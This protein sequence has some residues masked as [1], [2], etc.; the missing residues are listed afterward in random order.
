MDRDKCYTGNTLQVNVDQTYEDTV[1]FWRKWLSFKHIYSYPDF[2]EKFKS[3]RQAEDLEW[4][5]NS[6]DSNQKCNMYM[7]QIDFTDANCF[8]CCIQGHK[9]RFLGVCN[10]NRHTE[11]QE[12]VKTKNVVT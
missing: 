1:A 9:S 4:L 7:Y 12:S 2:S 8:V 5:R 10:T 3:Q 11:N 6:S